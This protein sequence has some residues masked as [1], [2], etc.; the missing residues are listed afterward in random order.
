MSPLTDDMDTEAT[1]AH[2]VR[3][4]GDALASLNDWHTLEQSVPS[5][6]TAD[7]LGQSWPSVVAA[8][9]EHIEA[10]IVTAYQ[11]LAA[12]VGHNA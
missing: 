9:I 8:Y 12:A 3:Q 7:K 10:T 5:W 11:T 1:L 6:F 4:R 2:E